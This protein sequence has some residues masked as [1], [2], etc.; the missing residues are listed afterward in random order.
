MKK[1]IV[2]AGASGYLG[3]YLV[4][5]FDQK[6]FEVIVLVRNRKKVTHL[7]EHMSQLIEVE[8]DNPK[9][10]KGLFEDVDYLVTSVGITRQK[11]G[12]TYMDVDYQCNKNLLDEAISGGVEK[13]MYVSALNGQELTQ[14]KIME[15]KEKFVKL[16]ESAPLESYVIRPSGFFG[17]LIEVF[18]MAKKGRVYL[19][20]DGQYKSNPIHGADL[21]KFCS[22]TFSKE[23]GTYDIG[24]PES[25]TQNQIA[26]MAFEILGKEPKI[27]LI[28]KVLPSII[29]TILRLVSNQRTYG[30]IEFFLTV[31]VMDMEAPLYGSHT[32]RAHF[33]SQ[34]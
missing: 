19:F 33:Q 13:F 31:L 11:D 29:K 1:R 4:K 17:D 23:T 20:G 27:T 9:A 32:L 8:L 30:P 3:Q 21:A 7:K 28:P 2:I 15:A 34:K 18:K 16:L 5:E 6:G 14:L 26:N 25:M 10:L 12:L 24:G 22:E